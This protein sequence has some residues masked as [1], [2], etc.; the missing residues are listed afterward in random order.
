MNIWL[1]HYLE[2]RNELDNID[3]V[4]TYVQRAR[5][6]AAKPAGP[7]TTVLRETRV[8]LRD[9]VRE[10]F[11]LDKANGEFAV[12]VLSGP[13]AGAMK[14]FFKVDGGPDEWVAYFVENLVRVGRP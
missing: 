10:A 2:H 12:Q 5:E 6:L 13:E 3:D 4:I 7:G 14:T 9:G 8:R 11:T 1:D